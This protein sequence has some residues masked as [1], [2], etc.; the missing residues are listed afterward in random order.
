M[1]RISRSA[2]GNPSAREIERTP[3][4]RTTARTSPAQTLRTRGAPHAPRNHSLYAMTLA[5]AHR[6]PMS[7]DSRPRARLARR[8]VRARNRCRRRRARGYLLYSPPCRESSGRRFEGL[9]VDGAGWTSS[10]TRLADH[11]ALP[12]GVD[13]GRSSGL[14]P[15]LVHTRTDPTGTR[16]HKHE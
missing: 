16:R 1:R 6:H 5:I 8:D 14:T 2:R 3:G 12:R 7:S 11:G 13:G 4:S 15:R 10:G 9:P